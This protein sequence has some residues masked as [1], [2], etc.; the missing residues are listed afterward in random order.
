MTL[1]EL[2]T[3][4]EAV[5]CQLWVEGELLRF[6]APEGALSPA[7]MRCMKKHK[8]AL[9]TALRCEQAGEGTA[10]HSQPLTFGQQAMW[11]LHDSTPESPAYNVASAAEIHS[12]LDVPALEQV[13][14]VLLARH[15]SLRTTFDSRGGQLCARV[16][17]EAPLDFEVV[18]AV[19]LSEEALHAQIIADYEAPFDLSSG[20]LSRL[21]IYQA[22][23]DR[24]IVLMAFHHIILDAWSL[25]VLH[26]ELGELYEQQVAGNTALLPAP[27]ATFEDFVRWQQETPNTKEGRNQWSYWR[28]QLEGTQTPAELPH[29]FQRPEKITQRGATHHFRVPN[30]LA[31]QLREVGRERGAT[32]FMTL[33]AVY[34]AALAK[35]SGQQDFLVGATTSGRTKKDFS[36][37]VGYFVNMLPLRSKLTNEMTFAESLEQTRE[38]VLDAMANQE[39]PFP[40]LVE[41]LNPE[42]EPGAQPL[43]RSLFGLQKPHDFSEVMQALDGRDQT[44]NWGGLQAAAYPLNQ[45]EGQFDLTLEMY[46]T[47]S[48]YLGVLKYN[49]DL[50]QLSTIERFAKHWLYL[51]EQVVENPDI[52]LSDL[53]LLNTQEQ[54]ELLRL[55]TG[56]AL[57]QSGSQELSV[58]DRF[59]AIANQTPTAV[60]LADETACLT[61]QQLNEHANQIA[62]WLQE[63]DIKSGDVV[64]CCQ[65]RGAM[66]WITHLACM[67]VG[68]IYAPLDETG[69]I[70]RIVGL[71]ADC[72]AK[73][74]LTSS[75]V[76]QRLRFDEAAFD[77]PFYVVDQLQEVFADQSLHN[78]QRQITLDSPAYV[79]YTSGTTGT[80][81]GVLITHGAFL[82]HLSRIQTAFDITARD[83]VLQFSAMTFDPSL[84]QAW[85]TWSVGAELVVRGPKLWSA[86]EFWSHVTTRQLTVVNLP[87]AY[88]RECAEAA[89]LDS[90]LRLVIVG[91]DAFPVESLAAWQRTGARI[92]NA[93]GPT[94]AVVTATISDVTQAPETQLS[95]NQRLPIGRPLA[96]TTALVVDPA[97]RL[98]PVGVAGELWLSSQALAEGYFGDLAATDARFVESDQMGTPQ[99]FYR[100]G[101]QVRWNAAGELE[102][103]GRQDRQVKIHGYRIELGEIEQTIKAFEGVQEVIAKVSSLPGDEKAIVVY[104]TTETDDDE[105]APASLKAAIKARLPRHMAPSHLEHLSEMPLNAAG[106]IAHNQLPKISKVVCFSET[107]FVAPQTEVQRIMADVWAEVLEIDR[108]GIHDNF[109]DLGGASL[110]SLKI[111]SLAEARGLKLETDSLSPSLLFE[112]PTVAELAEHLS[113]AESSPPAFAP[114]TGLAAPSETP[115]PQE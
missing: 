94:E 97:G 62:H 7:L 34:Q 15:D 101:D 90:S 51:A 1:D 93:Y 47:T 80:P 110:K 25:W 61:Y 23:A 22:S 76:A 9:I 103:I 67:K 37:V 109:F 42:R 54:Q 60:A 88:A 20:P 108:V 36:R 77:L 115:T 82:A 106:K 105:T 81:K 5:D 58:A 72:E 6:R 17:D 114:D 102:F 35:H 86:G 112:Y 70:E 29:D 33:L 84:E 27:A 63:V 2:R 11:L 52:A 99:R 32:P 24:C 95:G 92:L 57:A 69:P 74:L 13:W 55:S 3:E 44:I 46:E 49:T 68:A 83:R 45:Q 107:Q 71:L 38:C 73:I 30:E 113:L 4:L 10:A 96:N 91:G 89:P 79:I 98:V 64:G 12:P 16:H 66:A 28:K 75:S 87:P 85:S 100:T 19:A 65:S 43:C 39:L 21:R 50:Y 104:Y 48:T 40:L 8:Q 78:P 41:R 111:V 26:E 53:Q 18:D 31:E 56:P 59:E 14:R